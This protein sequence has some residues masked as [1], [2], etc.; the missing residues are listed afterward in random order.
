M[1]IILIL[2]F[3]F[4][5]YS[6]SQEMITDRPDQ[7]ESSS[8]VMPGRV[9]IE[10]G[11][12]I[13]K[14][15]DMEDKNILIPSTL[16]RVG[17]LP[18]F[19]F[20]FLIEYTQETRDLSLLTFPPSTVTSKVSGIAPLMIGAKIGIAEERNSLPEIALMTHVTLPKTGSEEFQTQYFAPEIRFSFS[21]TLRNDLS[22]SYNLGGIWDGI[23]PD[24]NGLYTLALGY[25]P[26]NKFGTYIEL[27]GFFPQGM[28][29]EHFIDGGFTYSILQ[30]LQLDLYAGTGLS[31]NAKN[32]FFGS[33]IS[34]RLPG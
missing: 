24:V 9:Q 18:N 10:S 14:N 26:M 31:E 25:N 30:N 17:V 34:V 8:L 21:H 28:K 6:F 33:G 1:K 11:I 23:S 3:I 5:M 27:Y 32:Y 2:V 20:R 15:R 29:S 13:E 22:L 4:P 12:L 19:E 16:F 7:T